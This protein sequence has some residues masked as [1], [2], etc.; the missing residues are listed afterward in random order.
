MIDPALASQSI[1][2]EISIGVCRSPEGCGFEGG[3]FCS[4]LRPLGRTVDLQLG[5]GSDF[6]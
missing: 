1:S 4:G 3:H 5:M 2:F 6:Y